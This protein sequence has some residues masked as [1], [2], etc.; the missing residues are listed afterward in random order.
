MKPQLIFYILLGALVLSFVGGG[1]GFYFSNQILTKS[2]NT[3]TEK[4]LELSNASNQLAYL[5]R[6]QHST[7]E[8]GAE[9]G[10][11]TAIY[12]KDKQQA[13]VIDQLLALAASRNVVLDQERI[14]FPATDGLPGSGSQLSESPVVPGLFGMT[15]GL[16]ISGSFEDTIAFMQD[17]ENF[18]RIINISSIEMTPSGSTVNTSLQLEVLVQQEAPTAATPAPTPNSDSGTSTPQES[19]GTAQ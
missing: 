10:D 2:G 5:Q 11:L 15:I 3:F 14:T 13:K 1:V 18:R 7:D 19:S 17:I 16:N 4:Q 6:L 12:P 9:L 8:L